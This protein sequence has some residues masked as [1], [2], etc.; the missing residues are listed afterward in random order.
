[1][2]PDINSYAFADY[3]HRDENVTITGDASQ[4]LKVYYT[5]RDFTLSYNVGGG[6]YIDAVTAPYGTQ[7]TLPSN[8]TRAGYTFAGWYKDSDCTEAA[9]SPYKLEANT[10]LY[11]KWNP[12]QSE[13]K[14]VY[15]IENANDDGYSYLATVTKTAP[16]DSS[17]T[18][19]AQT[20]G[21]NGTRPSELDTT[22]F[23]FKDSTT[24][25]VKADGTTVVIV[26][27]SRNVY[28]ITWNGEGYLTNGGRW[29]TGQGRATLSAKYGADISAQWTAT[30][31]TPHPTW[32]WNFSRTNNDEK[33]TSLDIMPSGNKTVYNWYYTTTKT[34]TLNYWFENYDSATTKTYNGRTYGLFKA[35]TVHYN[36]L[37]DTDYPDYAGYTKGGWV[38]SDGATRL[39][40]GT[41]NGSMTADF[42]Y[43]A[44]QYPLTFYNYNGTLISTQQ[45]TLNADISSYLTSNKPAVPMEGATWLGWFTDAE[46]TE[47]YSGGTKMPAGLVL[48]GDFQFPTRT[49]TFDSQGGTAVA[50]QTDE[51]GF[52]AEAPAD[53]TRDNYTFQGWFT[54][55]DETGSPYDWNQPVTKDI[56][57]YA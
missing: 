31:N 27:Y 30:F 51:Y 48:Y 2:T 8:A 9:A 19:T 28:T 53:P 13:Y 6:D 22:N 36:Y 11:A 32:C 18:M 44:L 4:E 35:V 54:A 46:H 39:T 25:T 55:A 50:A 43:N 42:Y 47:P 33:F 16:T 45:V 5:R 52:Y 56:T 38:R 10:T 17:I 57:L 15:M 41:P 3:H 1:M 49:V 40:A 37:Y 29:Q 14:I 26:K 24:E 7:I 21:A 23:T 34:Q 20:A 12:A